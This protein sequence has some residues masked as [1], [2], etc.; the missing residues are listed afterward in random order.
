MST[1]ISILQASGSQSDRTIQEVLSAFSSTQ[2]EPAGDST[3]L[4]NS[5][6]DMDATKPAVFEERWVRSD[7]ASLLDTNSN[8]S[9]GAQTATAHLAPTS[10]QATAKPTAVISSSNGK[11]INA[12][13]PPGSSFPD[14]D[15][16][17]ATLT[18]ST[19]L[20]TSPQPSPPPATTAGVTLPPLQPPSLSDTTQTVASASSDTAQDATP[21]LPPPSTLARP[22]GPAEPTPTT[23]SLSPSPTRDPQSNSPT[24]PNAD[25]VSELS[26]ASP[27]PDPEPVTATFTT[28]PAAP[29]TVVERTKRVVT[30][31]PR[32]DDFERSVA[33]SPSAA[34]GNSSPYLSDSSPTKPEPSALSG[35]A[36]NV[37]HG[38]GV[39]PSNG[40]TSTPLSTLDDAGVAADD[41]GH[42]QQ[43]Q[44]QQRQSQ[45]MHEEDDDRKINLASAFDGASV[46]ASNREARRPDRTIDDD[47]ES[48]MKNPCSASK[49]LII[50]LS[51]LGRVDAIELNQKEM[52]SSRVKGFRGPGLRRL[53]PARLLH[54]RQQEGGAAL[55]DAH[56]PR[57]RVRYL[58]LQ[59]LTHYG[60]EEV[61]A[62]NNVRVLGVT[63]ARELELAMT[64]SFE[65]EEE[66]AYDTAVAAQTPQAQPQRQPQPPLPA[67]P[68]AAAA[69]AA[70][71]STPDSAS[72][73]GKAAAA[74]AAVAGAL[75]GAAAAAAAVVAGGLGAAVEQGVPSP[76]TD[77]ALPGGSATEASGLLESLFSP[78]AGAVLLPDPESGGDPGT[79][80]QP[81]PIPT[82]RTSQDEAHTSSPGRAAD[83]ALRA[84]SE[85]DTASAT[86]TGHDAAGS[87]TTEAA[88]S[89]PSTT[90]A[91][92]LPGQHAFPDA[93]G[94]PLHDSMVVPIMAG[95]PPYIVSD[96]DACESLQGTAAHQAVPAHWFDRGDAERA[97]YTLPPSSHSHPPHPLGYANATPTDPSTP[98]AAAVDASAAV[99]PETVAAAAAAGSMI[100]GDTAAD[101]DASPTAP[102]PP[103]HRD[104]LAATTSDDTVLAHADPLGGPAGATASSL[105]T[106]GPV[107]SADVAHGSEP[108]VS[109]SRSQQPPPL[110]ALPRPPLWNPPR[111][112]PTLGQ[113][114]PPCPN[115]PQRSTAALPA[116]RSVCAQWSR[117]SPASQQT[118]PTDASLDAAS[119]LSDS[120]SAEPAPFAARPAPDHS[121][122][123]HAN[124]RSN[125]SAPPGAHHLT[126]SLPWGQVPGPNPGRSAVPRAAPSQPLPKG[127]AAPGVPSSSSRSSHEAVAAVAA[128]VEEIETQQLATSD[129][130]AD[131]RSAAA[132]AAV[133]SVAPNT[134]PGVPNAPS[135]PAGS[136][137]HLVSTLAGPGVGV[138]ELPAVS[139]VPA[140]VYGFSGMEL[141]LEGSSSTKPKP[142][143]NLFD[144]V[145]QEMMSLKLNQTKVWKYIK[146]LVDALNTRAEELEEENDRLEMR[147]DAL[148]M[149]AAAAP[150]R[151]EI[152]AWM[153][154]ALRQHQASIQAIIAA[155]TAERE[156]AAAA[157]RVQSTTTTLLG[158]AVLGMVLWVWS[159]AA[160]STG[161]GRVSASGR[162][163]GTG[164]DPHLEVGNEAGSGVLRGGGGGEEVRAWSGGGLFRRLVIALC[165]AN[166]LVAVLLHCDVGW[167]DCRGLEGCAWCVVEQLWRL[168]AGRRGVLL[169]GWG[170]MTTWLGG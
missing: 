24:S 1:S 138:G 124:Q 8:P 16:Q 53:D 3:L 75:G 56:P 169:R 12:N 154:L 144:V 59:F 148:A 50:E 39:L 26:S 100:S 65:V 51:Q 134:H 127:S 33:A 137:V 7:P 83:A 122:P 102:P 44:Q 129:V 22:S 89:S 4:Y 72:D 41:A 113:P 143:G 68:A 57:H 133:L 30:P 43:Q 139:P 165:V 67:A 111:P 156:A 21:E 163:S 147:V 81:P 150:T 52:Y 92:A 58:L 45:H 29:Y 40:G 23:E 146:E 13:T 159:G 34:P 36:N 115:T 37:I 130:Y 164:H 168:W 61:C 87:A 96:E 20:P 109:P 31:I 74:A 120:A 79:S 160:G 112:P 123:T 88:P 63:A 11:F 28:P 71:I 95:P 149:A 145:K 60:S 114:A 101:D 155:H 48:F 62:I 142:A 70:A 19:P 94:D 99:T 166:G 64:R 86:L 126:D 5:G 10:A 15:P 77:L 128:A 9:S 47:G 167:L 84:L 6:K 27:A 104:T 153:A 78:P 136:G 118:S 2:Q 93:S 110:S 54:S 161:S 131:A 97:S 151:P 76:V 117:L 162:V 80:T 35:R 119:I 121:T 135:G 141:L 107:L 157:A 17:E 170:D 69:A 32:P 98:S 85:P 18:A 158:S 116:A 73:A 42:Q 108:T 49:W 106:S 14:P 82:P 25:A 91:F 55:R 132:A 90:P 38:G 140:S 103:P 125:S 66:A 105:A 46:L 152:D